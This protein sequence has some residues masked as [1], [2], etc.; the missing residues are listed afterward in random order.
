MKKI[1]TALIL[2]VL[3]VTASGCA[4]LM[5]TVSYNP[6]G[7]ETYVGFS[8]SDSGTSTDDSASS[9]KTETSAAS[10]SSLFGK[11]TYGTKWVDSEVIGRVK[12]TDKIRLQDDF[13][14]AVNQ[15]WIVSSDETAMVFQ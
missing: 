14:A 10:V 1:I 8:E 2:E 6:G 4:P 5:N 3:I 15:E 11:S 12:A 7:N 13:A 9:G